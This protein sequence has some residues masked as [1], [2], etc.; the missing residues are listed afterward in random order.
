MQS[1]GARDKSYC[2][3]RQG[4]AK[5]YHATAAANELAARTAFQKTFHDLT[6]VERKAVTGVNGLVHL[7]TFHPGFGYE[8]F[9]EGLRPKTAN[10][11]MTF[12]LRDGIFKRLC[13][14][15]LKQPSRHFFLGCR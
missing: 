7:C 8:D 2:M 13:T 4:P 12:E 1:C 6:E 10:G 14:E 11:Q 9:I 3:A 5:T 15:A